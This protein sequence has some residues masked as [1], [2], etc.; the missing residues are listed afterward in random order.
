[1][2]VV[3]V[4][5]ISIGASAE[6]AFFLRDVTLTAG[7]D[8]LQLPYIHSFAQAELFG[9]EGRLYDVECTLGH[10][11]SDLTANY[12]IFTARITNSNGYLNSTTRDLGT[13]QEKIVDYDHC[14]GASMIAHANMFNLHQRMDTLPACTPPAPPSV[15]KPE[16]YTPIILDLETDGFHLSGPNPA[17]SFDLNADGKPERTAWTSAGEDEAFLCMDRNGNGII[18]DGRELFGSA[19]PL[20]SGGTDDSGYSALTELDWPVGGGNSDGR[21][22]AADPI[23]E[24]LCVWVDANRDGISQRQEIQSL[25]QAGVV[26]F[27]G[28]YKQMNKKDD[29]GNRFRYTS[30]TYMRARDGSVTSWPSF[31]VIF[32]VP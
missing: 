19:T 6:A 18:D 8:S 15:Q 11:V 27:D 10:S 20:M 32:A 3:A 4:F 7:K 13:G 21:I 24:R 2:S 30:R 5:I 31:D 1:V 14:Y 28:G 9:S 12:D 22:D 26:G 29:F 16:K 25:S 23:F 17:V